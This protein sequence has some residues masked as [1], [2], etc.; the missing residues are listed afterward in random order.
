MIR[1]APA[2]VAAVFLVGASLFAG[3]PPASPQGSP[4]QTGAGAPQQAP[5]LL[6]FDAAQAAA[7]NGAPL[8]AEPV[9]TCGAIDRRF[10]GELLQGS[11]LGF[12]VPYRLGDVTVSDTTPSAN[13]GGQYYVAGTAAA[14][15]VG[16]GDFPFD[17]PWGSDFNMDVAVDPMYANFPQDDGVPSSGAQHVELSAGQFPHTPQTPGVDGDTWP[18]NSLR[19]RTNLQPGYVPSVGDRVI[20]AGRW[21]NDCGHNNPFQT[22]LHPISF[23]GWAREDGPNSKTVSQAFYAPYR[24]MQQYSPDKAKSNDVYNTGRQTD[25][26]TVSFPLGLIQSMVKIQTPIDQGG[27]D[28]LESWGLLQAN[29]V[30]PVDWKVCAPASAVGQYVGLRYDFVARPGVEISY[31][32]DHASGCVTMKTKLGTQQTPNPPLHVCNT[33]WPF[34][35]EVAGA[36]AGVP[37]LDLKAELAKFVAPQY[38]ANLDPAPILDCYNPVEGPTASANPTGQ[39][40]S[41]DASML[42]PFYGR[43]EVFRTDVAPPTTTTASTTSSSTTSPSSSSSSTPAGQKITVTPGTVAAGGTIVVESSGW[44]A[45]AVVTV[46][47]DGQTLGTLTADTAGNVQGTFTVP[48]STSAGQHSVALSG[49]GNDG[50]AL[51]LSAPITVTAASAGGTTG[52]SGG[53]TTVSGSLPVTGAGIAT[54]VSIAAV[55]VLVGLGIVAGAR[56]RKSPA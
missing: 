26:T 30:S 7:A 28:H 16:A 6:E 52:G 54:L 5:S 19:A 13:D 15:S 42:A 32:A 47:L 22:E 9:R 48:S 20:V 43:L 21:V 34:L 50:K 24:E 41:T 14:S 2:A 25:P 10:L 8:S 4:P 29:Q 12:K 56:R 17:H 18:D 45:G 51:T 31:T 3:A 40:V 1:K 55:L 23:M 11:P 39:N 33:P 53:A 44:A 49:T 38:Q 35:N 36:E 27:I 37:N 46:M